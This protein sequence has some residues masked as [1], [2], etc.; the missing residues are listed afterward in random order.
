MFA[1]KSLINSILIRG[2]SIEMVAQEYETKPSSVRAWMKKYRI[3]PAPANQNSHTTS[4]KKEKQ[5]DLSFFKKLTP[6]SSF[7]LGYFFMDGDLK[8]N[9]YF[10]IYSKYRDQIEMVK[11]LLKAEA[12]VQYRRKPVLN[13]KV[14]KGALYFPGIQNPDFVDDL[15]KWG[16][17]YDKNSSIR[18]PEIPDEFFPYFARGCWMGSGSIYEDDGK[19]R[20]SFVNGSWAFISWFG[21]GLHRHGLTKRKIYTNKHTKGSSYYFIYA[22]KDSLKLFDVL[23]AK[24]NLN[25]FSPRQLELF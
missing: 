15:T 20:A 10:R 25:L 24:G 19:L 16:L 5:L 18:P 7:L 22:A 4:S 2:N 3:E 13:D 12:I 17:V 23:A 8:K 11:E 14:R 9:G 21:E 1:S 6:E